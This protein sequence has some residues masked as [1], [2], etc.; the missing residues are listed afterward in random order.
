MLYDEYF[1]LIIL[2]FWFFISVRLM[3]FD[4]V[5][6]RLNAIG[7]AFATR[8]RHHFCISA[9][10][11]FAKRTQICDYDR[12][13]RPCVIGDLSFPLADCDITSSPDI[14]GEVIK[15]VLVISKFCFWSRSWF[16]RFELHR[17]EMIFCLTFSRMRL[18]PNCWFRSV[19]YH[20]Q[21]D[22]QL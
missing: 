16:D 10:S 15:N 22:W 2:P 6:T 5:T 21:S 14:W 1:Y 13:S 9:L 19:I 8:T 7:P 17:H 4:A 12:F 20:Q 3:H 18:A 11:L